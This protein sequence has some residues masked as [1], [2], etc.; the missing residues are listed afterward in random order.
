MAALGRSE[1]L[2]FSP[3][4][5][6]FAVSVTLCVALLMGAV[7]RMWELGGQPMHADEAVQGMQ[8]AELIETGNYYYD[9]VHFHGPTLYY[10]TLPVAWLLGEREG[11]ALRERTL[12]LV[13]A[14]FGLLLA[15]SPLLLRA[16]LGTPGCMVAV[17]LLAFSP[18]LVY[19]SRYYIQEM[20]FVTAVVTTLLLFLGSG[21]RG[22][23][24]WTLAAG[25][26]AG[27]AI[28]TKETWMLVAA[29]AGIAAL[30][31][32][33]GSRGGA[34][35]P[36][37]DGLRR[38]GLAA[39]T[40]AITAGLFYSSFGRNPQGL[41]DAFLTFLL[42]EPVAGHDKDFGYYLGI[43]SQPDGDLVLLLT[44]VAAAALFAAG[45]FRR[46]RRPAP[47]ELFLF[48]FTV[49]LTGLLHLFTYKTPWLI[50]LPLASGAIFAG[51]AV[52]RL[53]ERS[54][55]RVAFAV[56]AVAAAAG[57]YSWQSCLRSAGTEHPHAYVPTHPE[58]LEVVALL[59]SLPAESP[60]FVISR[61]YWPLPWYLRKRSSVGYWQ[62]LPDTRVRPAAV[63]ADAHLFDSLPEPFTG[64]SFVRFFQLR[65]RDH[66]VLLMPRPTG[67]GCLGTRSARA[68]MA[69]HPASSNPEPKGANMHHLEETLKTHPQPQGMS[70]EKRRE[71]IATLANCA[72]TCRACADACLAE[73]MVEHLRQCIATD[74]ACAEICQ[75][76]ANLLTRQTASD[77]RV[78]ES[79]AETCVVACSTCADE[80]ESHAQEHAHCEHCGKACRECEKVC[81]QLSDSL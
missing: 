37:A 36:H 25:F 29:A 19:Y 59:E 58:T 52:S 9:P 39:G 10:L 50:L 79:M 43:L 68:G 81:R 72:C 6:R 56:V 34:D 24:G 20:I 16:R 28:A 66:R 14:I 44:F 73:P 22:G 64:P 71:L 11:D 77:L 62:E 70:A 30:F 1:V 67:D 69:G 32:R 2:Q 51:L 8:F 74:L 38:L 26:C 65:P 46:G 17:A 48:S 12:R 57:V 75:T 60:V 47:E 5:L 42:Y 54:R 63:V 78:L 53:P 3:V 55:S 31:A 45:I 61:N 15:A 80:C 7:L 4:K 18:G 33:L 49:I 21:M 27:L 35:R 76:L 40:A 13:P 41:A 23:R